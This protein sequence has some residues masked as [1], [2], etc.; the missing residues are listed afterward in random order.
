MTKLSRRTFLRGTG[1]CM[2]LPFMESMIPTRALAAAGGRPPM[3]TAIFSVSGGTVLESW[4]PEKAGPLGELPSIL[5]SFEFC[6]DDLTIVSGLSHNGKTEGDFNGHTSCAVLHL[7]APEVAKNENGKFKAGTSIDQYIAQN[8]GKETFLPSLEIGMG[9]GETRF[10]YAGDGQPVPYEA[11]PQMVFDRMFR[12]RKPQIPNWARNGNGAQRTQRA[13]E[14]RQSSLG[15]SVLDVVL[16]EAKSLQNKLGYADKQRLASYMDS[17]R[18]VE[19]RVQFLTVRQESAIAEMGPALPQSDSHG[20]LIV[21][22]IDGDVW[23]D[24][25]AVQHDPELHREYLG[26]MSDLVVLAFQTDSTRMITFAIG[27]EGY[28]FPGVVTVGYERHYHTLQHQGNARR[29]ED[30]DPISR[31]ACRQINSWYASMIAETVRKM[32][33]ID[34]GGT[35][36]LDNSQILYTSY[37]ADGGHNKHDYPAMLIGKAQGGLKG[38]QHIACDRKTPVANLYVEMANNMGIRTESFGDNLADYGKHRGRIP[39]LT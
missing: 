13:M 24:Q 21:P 16:D 32:K 27:E 11:N 15:Q 31:E 37:M 23:K 30:A 8:V 25:R 18:S 9:R 34:E 33:L 29:V 1:A 20:G 3:R 39:N 12:N 7:T 5:R 2:A 28:M 4:K 26:L 38:G 22:E 10:S 6:K 19:K 35:S 14:T 36:L 17:V